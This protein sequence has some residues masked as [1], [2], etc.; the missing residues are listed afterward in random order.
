MGIFGGGGRVLH[1]IGVRQNCV[2]RRGCGEC[3]G[4]GGGIVITV[5]GYCFSLQYQLSLFCFVL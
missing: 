3:G 5:S 4:E 2:I 1:Y